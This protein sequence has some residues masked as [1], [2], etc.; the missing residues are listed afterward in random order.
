MY[1][2]DT[3][4]LSMSQIVPQIISLSLFLFVSLLGI[5]MPMRSIQG[6]CNGEFRVYRAETVPLLGPSARGGNTTHAGA[7]AKAGAAS[8]HAAEIGGKACAG[9][10]DD[11]TDCAACY[12]S[13]VGRCTSGGGVD[14]RAG[15]AWGAHRAGAGTTPCVT[16]RAA[17]PWRGDTGGVGPGPDSKSVGLRNAVWAV[18]LDTVHGV[19][20]WGECNSRPSVCIV[21]DG[22]AACDD[23]GVEAGGGGCEEVEVDQ[24][25]VGNGVGGRP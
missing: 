20:A 19:G 6:P 18:V 17:V 10:E 16:A 15:R 21:D 14:G 5:F 23:G 12:G 9:E 13:G 1:G 8:A 2:W 24:R 11:A 22:P 25:G 7:G 4:G 3:D